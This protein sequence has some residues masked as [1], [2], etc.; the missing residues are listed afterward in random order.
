MADRTAQQLGLARSFDPAEQARANASVAIP[1]AT[2]GNGAADTADAAVD[3]WAYAA[4]WD[5]CNRLVAV[6]GQDGMQQVLLRVQDGIGAYDPSAPGAATAAGASTPLPLDSRRFLDQLEQVS[7][8][9]L[10]ALFGDDVFAA[11]ERDVLATRAAA[12][13]DYAALSA[14]AGDWGVPDTIR[15]LMAGWHFD[16]AR[17]AMATA[18]AWL[19]QRDDFVAQIREAGLAIPARL[20]DLW[21][22]DGG[23]T[24][25]AAELRAEVA[26]ASA[27]SGALED[28][29][30]DPNP[31]ERLGLLGAATPQQ[32]LGTAA[33][34]FADGDLTG[35]ADQ[36]S[37]A[38]TADRDAQATGV[39]RL[40][41]I[42]AIVAVVAAA[43]T[44]LWRRRRTGAT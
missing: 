43:A 44:L 12:R 39:V 33:G 9:D 25:A 41:I 40:A 28:V 29:G 35:A 34:L 4:S 36:I 10:D 21:R 16:E 22:S 32:L 27:Y 37:R 30:D 15:S 20:R 19:L 18:S 8:R 17:G 1:L 13:T 26:L 3:T 23:D 2:W 7:G 42:L 24:A 31:I 38:V 14:A 11:P 6:V 5:L